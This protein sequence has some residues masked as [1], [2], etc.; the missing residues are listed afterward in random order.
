MTNAVTTGNVELLLLKEVAVWLRVSSTTIYRLTES[1]RLPF[2]RV[3]GK[4]CF[5]KSD[6]LAYLAGQRVASVER[7]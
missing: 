1:R 6:V 4:L 3:G 5:L 2:I 7:N